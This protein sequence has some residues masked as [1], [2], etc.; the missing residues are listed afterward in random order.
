MYISS[1]RK[2]TSEHRCRVLVSSRSPIFLCLVVFFIF[3][4]T[5]F[6]EKHSR[7]IA[8]LAWL[9]QGT[10]RING[11]GA[12]I[13]TGNAI[14]PGSLLQPG[15]PAPSPSIIVYLADGRRIFYECSTP[16][17]CA[18]GFRVPSLYR[19]PEPF[20]VDMLSRIHSTLLLENKSS[21]V[22]L[23]P[24]LPREEL[25]GVLDADDRVTVGGLVADLPNGGYT[26]DLQP[27][28]G[29]SPTRSH[30]AIEKAGPAI[31]FSL[32]GPG[33]YELTISDDLNM[34]RI[35][36]F[37]AAILPSQAAEFKRSFDR[38]RALMEHWDESGFD[39]PIHDFQR[40]YLESLMQDAPSRTNNG[41]TV[42]RR[43]VTANTGTTH[44][45]IGDKMTTGETLRD[46]VTAEPQLFP[47]PGDFD[48]D[49]AVVLRSA[50][51]G[52]TIHFTVDDSEPVAVSPIYSAPIMVKGTGLTIK[53]FASTP[54]RKDS[55]VVTGIYRIRGN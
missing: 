47:K 32:P 41:L 19:N 55:A 20:A 26:Y 13:S 54:G 21:S 24:R 14:Q 53:S 7:A 25:L 52:S 34:P 11:K 3:A 1:K 36:L 27:L 51:P 39:W 37:V 12:P 30:I 2:R 42:A 23:E 44:E 28:N 45:F 8:G 33:M 50:T 10:W 40:A 43:S 18:R 4:A 16:E 15:T 31:V 17:D 35:D 5:L 38:A 22:R 46:G 6:A 29:A 49:A 48:G 9:V